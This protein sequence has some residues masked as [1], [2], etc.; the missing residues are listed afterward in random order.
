MKNISKILQKSNLTA[1]ER[2]ML[3]IKNDIHFFKTDKDILSET[4]KESLFGTGY[5]P[6]NNH[7]VKEYNKYLRIWNDFRKLEMELQSVFL[8]TLLSLQDLEKILLI[9]LFDRDI[10][11]HKNFLA[12]TLS[13]KEKKLALTQILE[14]TGIEYNKLIHVQT[15]LSIPEDLQKDMILLHAEVKHDSSYFD[16]EEKLAHI[17]KGKKKLSKKDIDDLTY[18]FTNILSWER[19]AFMES[20]GFDIGSIAFSGYFAGY[21]MINFAYKL[22]EKHHISF[23]DEEDLTK[24]VSKIKNLRKEYEI[25]IRESI[26]NG[27]FFDE[28]VPMCNSKTYETYEGKTKK[29]HNK[30]L[31]LWLEAKQKTIIDVQKYIDS[32]DL[33]IEE[34]SKTIFNEEEKNKIITGTSL[35]YFDDS[36]HFVAD[37][38][39]QVDILM[40]YG[41]LISILKQKDISIIYGQLLSFKKVTD[42]L[43]KIVGEE[44]SSSGDNYIKEVN[45]KI[46]QMNTMLVHIQDKMYETVYMKTSPDF[47]IDI[48]F[49]LFKIDY[50]E[51]KPVMI[52]GLEY[53]DG[54]AEKLLG[55]EWSSE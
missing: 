45:E 39:K 30:I 38:I 9:Y 11:K 41:F 15:F 37:Y 31:E 24:K 43:S 25:I 22:A 29:K 21:A 44:V 48:H 26:E 17:L 2:V 20:K 40:M 6:Q 14:S 18:I 46:N 8:T 54:M 27:L 53:F 5:R 13:D 33:V 50:S 35:Y 12:G 28:Y 7:E 10:S 34:Q 52:H 55:A 3:M 19:V 1:R 32:G 36:F 16:E 51:I 23:K 49:K 47:F 42:K 4:D